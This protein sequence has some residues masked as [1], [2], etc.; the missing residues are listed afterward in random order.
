MTWI[1][2]QKSHGAG[3]AEFLGDQ[4]NHFF[5]VAGH[6]KSDDNEKDEKF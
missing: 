2:V 4:L 3:K 5:H 6:A 1:L